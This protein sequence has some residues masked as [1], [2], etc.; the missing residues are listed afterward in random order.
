MGANN[1]LS[2]AAA[3]LSTIKMQC[4]WLSH[5]DNISFVHHRATDEMKALALEWE[6]FSAKLLE[7]GSTANAQAGSID[8][9]CYSPGR[10]LEL[11]KQPL[12]V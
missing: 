7:Q 3:D 6:R 2:G 5:P 10:T 1:E 9:V 11:T 12:P 4:I 8:E